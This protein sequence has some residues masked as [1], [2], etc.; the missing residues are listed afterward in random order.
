[1]LW[2]QGNIICEWHSFKRCTCIAI[3]FQS[4]YTNGHQFSDYDGNSLVCCCWANDRHSIGIADCLRIGIDGVQHPL[5]DARI[6]WDFHVQIYPINSV[7]HK[8]IASPTWT[9]N[10]RLFLR[11]EDAHPS[12]PIACSEGLREWFAYSPWCR[13]WPEREYPSWTG[14]HC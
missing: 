4:L 13:W 6:D 9:N 7:M 8:Y 10:C 2:I 5:D 1:M 3:Q 12:R 14:L 11:R